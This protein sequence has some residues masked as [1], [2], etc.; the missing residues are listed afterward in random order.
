[1]NNPES[2]S[3]QHL[4]TLPHSPPWL[5]GALRHPRHCQAIFPTSR[6]PDTGEVSWGR[7]VVVGPSKLSQFDRGLGWVGLG[8]IYVF[9]WMFCVLSF[10]KLKWWVS[11][12]QGECLSLLPWIAGVTSRLAG[13]VANWRCGE[14]LQP[15]QSGP[16]L[17]HSFL[18]RYSWNHFTCVHYNL[19]ADVRAFPTS[20]KSC[21]IFIPWTGRYS[22]SWRF[23]SGDRCMNRF[24]RYIH[25]WNN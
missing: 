9:P 1:M 18:G 5:D 14:E 21:F 6:L 20:P 23:H 19:V 25:K 12:C 8:L 17:D 10:N 11:E 24:H 4:T 7:G 15:R 16:I 13:C 2:R 22:R 3:R